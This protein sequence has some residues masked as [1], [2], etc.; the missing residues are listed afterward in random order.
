[1]STEVALEQ[2]SFRLA[3]GQ[4][5]VAR[6]TLDESPAESVAGWVM[7]FYIRNRRGNLVLTKTTG[8][9]ITCTSGVT[10]IWA[11]AFAEEDSTFDES[12]E[13]TE[14]ING[15][16]GLYNWSLWRTDDGSETPLAVGT[17]DVFRT[18]K[19]A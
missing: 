7:A 1:V 9:G 10:G 15:N 11:V 16:A 13:P 17:C 14:T 4:A 2:Q 19:T 12:N 18:S 5:K 8:S 3:I 6:F